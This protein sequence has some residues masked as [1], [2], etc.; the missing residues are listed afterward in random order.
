MAQFKIA[1][2]HV[3]SNCIENGRLCPVCDLVIV[4]TGPGGT[5]PYGTDWNCLEISFLATLDIFFQGPCT[6]GLSFQKA[7]LPYLSIALTVYDL[8]ILMT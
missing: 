6:L 8:A 7:Y 4:Y 5:V 2:S 1:F 3:E